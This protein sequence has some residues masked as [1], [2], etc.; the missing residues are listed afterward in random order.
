MS[1]NN[2]VLNQLKSKN[3]HIEAYKQIILASYKTPV[4]ES[5]Q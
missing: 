4:E 2:D 1:E 3:I 5:M